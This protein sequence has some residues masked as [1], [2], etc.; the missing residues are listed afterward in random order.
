[1]SER[2]RDTRPDGVSSSVLWAL[3]VLAFVVL[4]VIGLQRPDDDRYTLTNRVRL[5]M[6]SHPVVLWVIRGVI[7]VGLLWLAHHFLVVDPGTHPGAF[8]RV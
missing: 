1:M 7:A 4:E 3:W 8:V 2:I 5:L 6:R